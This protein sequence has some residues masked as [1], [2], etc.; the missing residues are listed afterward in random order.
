MAEIRKKGID[1][2]WIFLLIFLGVAFPLIFV[3]GLPVETTENTQMVY[4]LVQST[5]DGTTVLY[6][7]DY[8]PAS[9]PELHPMAKA[10]LRHSIE[11]KQKLI[12]TAL[13][14]MGVLMVDD[15]M[16]QLTAE[17]PDLVYGED[18][19]NL[20][21]KAGGMVTIQAMGKNFREVYPQDTGGTP[22]DDLPI[23][24]NVEN[25]NNIS[26]ICSFSAG[27]PGIKEWVQIGNNVYSRPVTGGV[28]G[29]SAPSILPYVNQQQQ[30]TGLL[31][32]LKGAAEYEQLVGAEDLATAGMD[33]QSLA[34]LIIIIFIAIG[35]INYWRD[36]KKAKGEK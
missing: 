33:A 29:V 28:T 12:F 25:F 11:K 5:N 21:F 35:N 9:M 27:A 8:D 1:R 26:F 7:F 2:R 6:S 10:M 24:N 16:Q 15:L 23:M 17:Y 34:H 32:G 3:I 19:V 31:A 13:W 14:P 18:Y 4:D 30:L 22:I 20:G 36:K